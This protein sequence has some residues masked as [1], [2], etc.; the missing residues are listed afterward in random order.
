MQGH[1]EAD[2]GV[3]PAVGHTETGAHSRRPSSRFRIGGV[4]VSAVDFARTLELLLEAP[5]DG[6]RLRAHFA[7]AHTIAE[8]SRDS[9]L[10]GA[11][12]GADLVAPDGLPL[13]WVGRLRGRR[14]GRV[15]GPDLMLAL[16]DRSR[17]RGYGHYFY[18]GG[19]GTAE[20]LAD[21]MTAR[22]PGL[23]VAGAESPPFRPL[24]PDERAATVARINA[25]GADYV[26]VG[27]GT[28]KQDL[29]LAEFRAELTAPVLLA[30][31]A[32]F[33]F[34]SGGRRRAPRLMQRTGTEWL[35]R[36]ALEPRRLAY[37]YT[38]MNGRFAWLVAK[39]MIADQVR[40]S[41]HRA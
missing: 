10:H 15:C 13:V 12:D 3:V 25:A 40:R 29:W 32:A 35:F 34:L 30:V 17:E 33:D 7:T 11:L 9:R 36:L 8:A 37:R 31:G 26:W 39:S 24:S 1:Q 4:A 19:R 2:E 20:R 21:R 16:L 6:A 23:V 28:P 27:L 38:V 18:G 22:F 41:R 5:S 14:M